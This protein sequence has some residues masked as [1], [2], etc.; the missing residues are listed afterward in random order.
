MSHVTRV[1]E[2]CHTRESSHWKSR[3][4]NSV[5]IGLFRVLKGLFCVWIGLFWVWI[6]LL[7]VLIKIVVLRIIYIDRKNPPPGGVSFDQMDESYHT[8][9]WVTS[10]IWEHHVTHTNKSYHTYE[11]DTFP[12]WMS[13]ATHAKESYH[14]CE[15][16][17]SHMWMSHVTHICHTYVCH[18]ETPMVM[19]LRFRG[20]GFRV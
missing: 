7:C 16:V 11:W 6:G 19:G 1:N 18:T 17:I 10:H 12:S 15:R 20:L 13:H 9:E 2:P 14:T 4:R 5:H 3:R 8:C